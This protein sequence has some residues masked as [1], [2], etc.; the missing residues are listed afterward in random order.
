ML[1]RGLPGVL[2]DLDEADMIAGTERSSARGTVTISA[3]PVLGEE[4]LRR[5]STAFSASIRASRSG[6]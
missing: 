4:V 5:L 1:R 2:V 3:P 6:F